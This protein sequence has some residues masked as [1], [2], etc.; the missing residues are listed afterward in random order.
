MATLGAAGAPDLVPITFAPVGDLIY[1]AVDHKAKTTRDLVRLEN[2]RRD[3][4]VTLLVDEYNDDWSKLWW[5]R[6]RGTAQ[7]AEA[8]E[9]FEAGI[10]A[11]TER[12][13]Q[14]RRTRLRGPVIVIAVQDSTGWGAR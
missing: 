3:P 12:Y 4:R 8:G 7:V 9:A 10:A 14:Y 1:T 11:L 13:D 2:I 5:C 6:L